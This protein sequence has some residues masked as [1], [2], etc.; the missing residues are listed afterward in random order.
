MAQADPPRAETHLDIAEAIYLEVAARREASFGVKIHP[1]IAPC[2]QGLGLVAYYRALVRGHGAA[3]RSSYLREA[4]ARTIEALAQWEHIEA[5]GDGAESA[6]S[7]R[8]LA[9][10]SLARHARAAAE[11]TLGDWPRARSVA[12]GA[13]VEPVARE[14][15]R[16]MAQGDPPAAFASRQAPGDIR[17]WIESWVTDPALI[18]LVERFGGKAPDGELRERLSHLGEFSTVWDYRNGRERNL[19]EAR[20]DDPELEGHVLRAA[21][22]L[23][24]RGTNPP[25]Y[26]D[27]DA[28]IILGGL[29]RACLARP[30][31]AA[32]LVE[33]RAITTRRVIALGGYRPLRGDEVEMARTMIGAEIG[34]EL[35]AMDAGVRDAFGLAAPVQSEGGV[36]ET[37]GAGWAHLEYRSA[38]GLPVNVVAA[39][40]SEPGVRRAN[41]PDTYRWLVS[42]S[43][44]LHE[45][46]AVL[47]V[48]TDIYRPF[49]GADALRMLRLP[50]N[51]H[52]DIV[53][54]TAGEVDHRLAQRF[55]PH[56]YLQE[57]RSTI[58][59]LG[60]LKSALDRGST[61]A[62]RESRAP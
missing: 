18:D 34:D 31:H 42:D 26:R 12:L 1:Q 15:V 60:S 5:P 46:D 54:I 49:Q 7:A 4:S 48:T 6:K 36:S 13:F 14:A 59:A 3:E 44:L 58:L 32:R 53:G 25:A 10:I 50:L 2:L 55:E 52:V 11:E 19:V 38:N 28:V 57:L 30:G 35:H 33:Q 20:L 39:P 47:V 23:G 61:P 37:V 45:N 51:V 27:Y 17:A 9:K 56:S 22:A 24:L 43:G 29:V 16:E 62:S 40:S 21:A 8:A 41:T